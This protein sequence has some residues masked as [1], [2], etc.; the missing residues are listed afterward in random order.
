MSGCGNRL[1]FRL[2]ASTLLIAFSGCCACGGIARIFRKR[3][4]LGRSRIYRI[5][6]ATPIARI[7]CIAAFRA[8][9]LNGAAGIIMLQSRSI[10]I[11][12][13]SASTRIF[14]N[15]CRSASCGR[16]CAGSIQVRITAIVFQHRT[17]I[18]AIAR[19]PGAFA[20]C[21]AMLAP[22]DVL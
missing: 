9:R 2:S 16:N 22:I 10:Y 12:A 19:T 8:S 18:S 6:I 1:D 14:N 3:M 20:M 21:L 7:I 11:I 4:S 15:T 17:W 5:S 13:I